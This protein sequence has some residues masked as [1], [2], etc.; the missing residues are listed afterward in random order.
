VRERKEPERE[1]QTIPSDYPEIPKQSERDDFRLV[2]QVIG[3][4]LIVIILSL[5]LRR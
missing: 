3:M 5:L 1:E 2:L 4:V